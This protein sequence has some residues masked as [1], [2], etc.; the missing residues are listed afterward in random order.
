V[1]GVYVMFSEVYWHL[2]TKNRA[3]RDRDVATSPV[4]TGPM[5]QHRRRHPIKKRSS[6]LRRMVGSFGT[7]SG[8]T[9]FRDATLAQSS[10][11]DLFGPTS[12]KLFKRVAEFN[13]PRRIWRRGTRPLARRP[14][15]WMV[16]PAASSG[17][18]I[19][20]ALQRG[21]SDRSAHF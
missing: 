10:P 18:S 12:A 15:W 2:T 6:Y 14:Y 9:R 4:C 21:Q 3:G 7:G 13:I 5:N 16:P 11:S 1:L 8:S 19:G 20:A 17:R